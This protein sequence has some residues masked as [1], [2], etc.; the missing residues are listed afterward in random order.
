M[1]RC[2]HTWV[3]WR[4]KNKTSMHVTRVEVEGHLSPAFA[5]ELFLPLLHVGKCLCGNPLKDLPYSTF[6]WR[7]RDA[8]EA[9]KN[10][11]GW[12]GNEKKGE[13]HVMGVHEQWC[14]FWCVC[15][16]VCVC[17]DIKKWSRV[18][19][20]IFCYLTEC[21][22]GL[23]PHA[24]ELRRGQVVLL[25]KIGPSLLWQLCCYLCPVL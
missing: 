9:E 21:S 8:T 16:C 6:K 7:H 2:I 10:V 24:K 14:R 19:Q 4:D 18:K 25:A 17:I 13:N 23:L 15:V 12:A 11:Q 5:Q 20:W 22:C 1:C 3:G